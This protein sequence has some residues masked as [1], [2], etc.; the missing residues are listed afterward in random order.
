LH[1]RLFWLDIFFELMVRSDLRINPKNR[2]A[3]PLRAQKPRA[4]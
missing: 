2:T 3:A 4:T 1:I